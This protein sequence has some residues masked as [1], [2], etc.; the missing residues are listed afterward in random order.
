MITVEVTACPTFGEL[1]GGG[2]MTYDAMDHML[3][4]DLDLTDTSSGESSVLNIDL[5]YDELG[6]LRTV[7]YDSTE[8]TWD[9]TNPDVPVQRDFSYDPNWATGVYERTGPDG[10]IT[11]IDTDLAGRA[12]HV[13]RNT[14]SGL[15]TADMTYYQSG[16]S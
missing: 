11:H 5:G 12:T 16:S 9:Q 7:F 3:T 6:R 2:T 10:H 8:P 13:E 1:R 15:I 4:A 14:D